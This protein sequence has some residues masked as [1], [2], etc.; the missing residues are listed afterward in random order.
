MR[1]HQNPRPINLPS[2]LMQSRSKRPFSIASTR[3]LRQVAHF[4]RHFRHG[5]VLA[6][7]GVGFPVAVVLVQQQ[8][9]RDI[10][11]SG[12]LTEAVEGVE[13]GAA[14]GAGGEEDDVGAC[15]SSKNRWTARSGSPRTSTR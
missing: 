3:A 12:F 11:E 9:G 10:A 8:H 15:G 13:G 14:V 1:S 5:A 6:D 7:L 4:D 2:R